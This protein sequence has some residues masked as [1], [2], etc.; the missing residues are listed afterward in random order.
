MLLSSS[1]TQIV[2]LCLTAHSWASAWN[3]G[4]SGVLKQG[5]NSVA[6]EANPPDVS[7][8]KP[9]KRARLRGRRLSGELHASPLSVSSQTGASGGTL[10]ASSG[11]LPHMNLSAASVNAPPTYAVECFNPHNP[12]LS[13]AVA[14]DCHIVIDH[15][16]LRYPNLMEPQ[17]FGYSDFVTIDLRK[18]ENRKWIFGQCVIFVRALDETRVDRFRMVDV[19]STASRIVKKCVADAKHPNGG[20]SDVGSTED[21]FYV[22]VGGVFAA[23]GLNRTVLS[24]PSED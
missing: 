11:I 13:P 12:R 19:A 18:P 16:I 22:G 9:S 17:T 20:M 24:L 1:L 23:N 15:I 5:A 6:H 4:L 21:Y 14:E 2:V 3:D 8:L 10:S 7:T